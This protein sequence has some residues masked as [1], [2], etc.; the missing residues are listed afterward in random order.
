M[1]CAAYDVD[2]NAHASCHCCAEPMHGLSLCGGWQ[3]DGDAD[4]AEDELEGE[5]EG[6]LEDEVSQ[7]DRVGLCAQPVG[8]CGCR[9]QP[10]MSIGVPSWLCSGYAWS[11]AVHWAA[12]GCGTYPQ[13]SP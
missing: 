8:S 6:A 4:A 11:N 7:Q 12:G 10:M 13:E 1:P 3:E 2:R 5:L 9:A